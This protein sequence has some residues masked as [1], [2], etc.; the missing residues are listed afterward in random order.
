MALF[1]YFSSVLQCAVLTR[2]GSREL[3][4]DSGSVVA[5]VLKM[6]TRWQQRKGDFCLKGVTRCLISD[7]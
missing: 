3:K 5:A 2:G 7:Y 6:V 1:M 4:L